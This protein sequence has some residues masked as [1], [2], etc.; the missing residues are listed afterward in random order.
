[1][2]ITVTYNGEFGNSMF[3]YVA[4]R[5][6]AKDNGLKF[7][8]PWHRPDMLT[9]REPS[10]GE[11][12]DAPVYALDDDADL[13]GQKYPP[14]NYNLCGFW[15]RS[16]WYVNRRDEILSFCEPIDM[17]TNFDDLVMHVRM[18]NAN[19]GNWISPDWYLSILEHETF[20]RLFIVTDDP[21]PDF[22]CHFAKYSPLVISTKSD[23]SDWN[24]LRGFD[25]MIIGNSTFAWWSAFLSNARKVYTFSRWQDQ[26]R[27]HLSDIPNGIPVDG[28]FWRE[29]PSMPM[30]NF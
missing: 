15:Q 7:M 11:R 26:S 12:Y 22:L 3:Q 8:S 20:K 29:L 21:R 9:M 28:K 4:G 18:G 27:F 17:E 13:F 24:L 23:K 30:R 2:S 10:G 14:G 16:A 5:L 25:R 1:M 19:F 6:F